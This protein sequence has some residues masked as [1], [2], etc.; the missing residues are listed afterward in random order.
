MFLYQDAPSIFHSLHPVTKLFLLLILIVLPFLPAAFPYMPVLLVLNLLLLLIAHGAPNLARFWK[1][2]IIFWL[3][4]FTIWIVIPKLRGIPWSYSLAATLATRVDVMVLAGLWFVTVTRVEEF[5][6]GLTG[7]GVPY[8][9]AFALS[10]GFRLVP[11][12]YQN[13]QVII[14]AQQ[15][16]GA[17][18]KSGG[19]LTRARK[20]APIIGVLISYGIRNAEMTAMSLEAKGF[21]YSKTRTH[22]VHP[23]FG[24][25]DI[26]FL[27]CG[28]AAIL[29]LV[30]R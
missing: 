10:L 14:A 5:V 18:L 11:L 2:L 13:L 26:L 9:P 1:L 4:T 27:A 20:Y 21:G 7:L 17:D 6:T 15:S 24:I 19:L 12:F 29:L 30:L 23:A 16:R 25:R 22:Y 28:A 8:K 3:F